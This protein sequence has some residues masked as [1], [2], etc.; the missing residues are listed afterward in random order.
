MHC[1]R[2][3]LPFPF[4]LPSLP[5]LPFLPSLPP[6]LRLSVTGYAVY[7]WAKAKDHYNNSKQAHIDALKSGGEHHAH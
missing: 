5:F 7:T 6:F 4:S 2:L 3:T 1:G